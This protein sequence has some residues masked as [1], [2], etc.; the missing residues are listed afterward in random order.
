MSQIFIADL[1]LIEIFINSDIGAF[2]LTKAEYDK[3]IHSQVNVKNNGL[4]INK[5]KKIMIVMN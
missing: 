5:L 4:I 1:L 3:V 2:D